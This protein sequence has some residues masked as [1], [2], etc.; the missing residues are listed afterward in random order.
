MSQFST[1]TKVLPEKEFIALFALM[2][3]LTALSMDAILP[4]FQ[5]IAHD[6]GIQD[7]QKTQWIVSSLIVGMVF[8]ELLFGPLSDSIGRK[9]SILIGVGIYILGSII[10]LSSSSLFMLLLGRA[11][12][13][14]G[15]AGPKIAS[16]ALIRDLYQ[17]P[18]MARIMSY[19]MV[20]FIL[21]P[22]LA[23]ALGQLVMVFGSWRWVFAAFIVQA[24][25]ASFWL[26][27]RQAE[28]L[29][30]E[31]SRPL[32]FSRLL[33]DG[34]FILSQ[35]DVMAYTTIAGCIFGGLMLYLSVA[36]SVFQDIYQTGEY[37]PLYFAILSIG[38]GLASFSNGRLVHRLG[39]AFSVTCALC[40]LIV[41]SF[42]L[43]CLCFFFAGSPPFYAFMG[44]GILIFFSYGLVF[45]NI[46]AMALEP[47]GNMAGLAASIISSLSSLI[48]VFVSSSIGQFY[49]LTV[50]PLGAGFLLLACISLGLLLLA[51]KTNLHRNTG[52]NPLE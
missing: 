29:P 46:N 8:G 48:A 26:A 7:Y 4:G 22:I 13:G 6:L 9:K 24:F 40:L 45:G 50:M 43:L 27:L 30:R 15:V 39:M 41:A 47:L 37:F 35:R 14:L 5:H 23:P 38:A 17:G 18:D 33:N 51:K 11:I 36:Q 28:T 1:V 3:S 21:V 31:Q 52:K 42:V 20:I 32:S 49:Y 19:V 44:L 25:I 34:R 16:R 12:Q 2:M 10:A